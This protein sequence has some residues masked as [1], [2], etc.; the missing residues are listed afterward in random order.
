VLIPAETV[1]ELIELRLPSGTLTATKVERQPHAATVAGDRVFVGN[2]FGRSISVIRGNAIVGRIG[3]LVQTGGLTTVGG[4]VA[5]V[6]VRANIVSLYDP[7]SLRLMGTATARRG[8]THAVADNNGELYVIDTRG[9]AVLTYA[10][11]HGLQAR[12]RV[13]L[14]GTPYG[15]AI[16]PSRH[17]LWIT[18]TARNQLVELATGAGNGTLR[19]LDRYPTGRQPNTVAVD[20]RTG[21]VF[22][23]NAA[24]GTVE[25][26]DPRR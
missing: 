11:R 2:E 26:I 21:R 9:D 19:S 15:V 18:L 14:P 8:P 10:T 24:D 20:T 25:P 22:V 13:A 17:R 5:E 1:D 16:D 7:R 12:S 3:G 23:A 4:R 6:D